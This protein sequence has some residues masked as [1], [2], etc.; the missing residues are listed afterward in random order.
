MYRTEPYRICATGAVHGIQLGLGLGL[1]LGLEQS[2]RVRVRVSISGTWH[3]EATQ[4]AMLL[5]SPC[6]HVPTPCP[7]RA[8]PQTA[9]E[10]P[11]LVDLFLEK[12]LTFAFATGLAG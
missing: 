7:L 4:E 11:V 8:H 9:Q 5:R 6:P 1:G 2:F 3:P 10:A 12:C